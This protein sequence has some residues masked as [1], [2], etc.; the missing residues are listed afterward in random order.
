MSGFFSAHTDSINH[1]VDGWY[2]S[3]FTPIL[4]I[5]KPLHGIDD[6][7]NFSK[8]CSSKLIALSNLHPE[9]LLKNVCYE[10]LDFHNF[11]EF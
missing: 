5:E 6:I 4:N 3:N 9:L 11:L 8:I 10:F 1:I 2:D 7:I